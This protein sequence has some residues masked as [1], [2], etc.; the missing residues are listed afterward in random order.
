[1]NTAALLRFVPAGI[2]VLLPRPAYNNTTALISWAQD[3]GTRR[4][5]ICLSL[6]ASFSSTESPHH[7]TS[8]IVEILYW[9]EVNPDV[10]AGSCSAQ[11]GN[12]LLR[13]RRVRADEPAE[14]H[15]QTGG[16]RNRQEQGEGGRQPLSADRARA[17]S[18]F[19]PEPPC[20]LPSRFGWGE[21]KATRVGPG[22]LFLACPRMTA[23]C[24]PRPTSATTGQVA[25]WASGAAQSALWL[26]WAS[27]TVPPCPSASTPRGGR[28]RIVL[29]VGQ[30]GRQL[31]LTVPAIRTV[32]GEGITR[33]EFSIWVPE[34]HWLTPCPCTSHP[35]GSARTAVRAHT[36]TKAVG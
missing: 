24:H 19:H 26:E 5:R 10:R 23:R 15:G 7:Q 17:P 14:T 4:A 28:T 29:E 32:G 13:L 27:S 1:M 22:V 35:A 21:S 30:G 2:N 6:W 18:C 31:L 3:R 36:H 8:G 11:Q 16:S 34:G 25:Q 20:N 9:G 12:G 33:M